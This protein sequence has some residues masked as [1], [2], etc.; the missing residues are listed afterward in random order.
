MHTDATQPPPIT[1]L[2]PHAALF[3]SR[4]V[5]R[6]VVDGAAWF[7]AVDVVARLGDGASAAREWARLR[8]AAG[9]TPAWVAFDDP[10]ADGAAE[11]L[12]GLDKADVLRLAAAMDSPAAR[13]VQA[14]TAHAAVAEPAVVGRWAA[15][16][17]AAKRPRQEL[18]GEWHARGVML[19]EQYRTLTNTLFAETFGLDVA[20]YRRLKGLP[21]SAKLRDHMTTAELTLVSLAESVAAEILRRRGV[22][23][24]EAILSAT[25]DA[26]RAA[27]A[28]RL[29][30]EREL[31][32]AAVTP[33]G[34]RAAAA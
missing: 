21:Q 31:G 33:A 16:R 24:F 27:R 17:D 30:V 23:G 10:G 8:D 19:P 32:T 25:R 11:A 1:P 12:E 26:G 7:A 2:D 5:R 15:S 13:R 14:W 20:A 9:L 34:P 28:A 3:R 22:A 6:A 4:R 29:A 18:A